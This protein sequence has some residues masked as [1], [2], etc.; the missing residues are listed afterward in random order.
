MDVRYRILKTLVNNNGKMDYVVLLNSVARKKP[1][2]P[3]VVSYLRFSGFISGELRADTSVEI[4]D[5]GMEEYYRLQH[6]II[7]KWCRVA[8]YI[9]TTGVAV[10]ALVVSFCQLKQGNDGYDNCPCADHNCAYFDN[11]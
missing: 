9:L 8:G 4:L 11:G 7:E 5:K 6:K 2:L 3:K 1:L 10:A